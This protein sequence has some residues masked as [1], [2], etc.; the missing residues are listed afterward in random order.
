MNAQTG[1]AFLVLVLIIY[2]AYETYAI[3]RKMNELDKLRKE[4]ELELFKYRSR[5]AS[6]LDNQEAS[7]N[8][9]SNIKE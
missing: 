3:Q 1:I 8:N 4:Q 6:D 5:K 7:I 2:F 9:D